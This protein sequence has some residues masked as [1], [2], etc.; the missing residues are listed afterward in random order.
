[1]QM[2]KVYQV[3]MHIECTLD[4]V[5]NQSGILGYG[6]IECIFYCFDTPLVVGTGTDTTDTHCHQSAVSWVTVFHDR[7]HPAEHGGRCI[8]IDDF[9]ALIN[10]RFHS[11]VAFNPCNRVNDDMFFTHYAFSSLFLPAATLAAA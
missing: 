5:T 3:V 9:I 7:L 11:Q 4:Q 6:N 1:M 8:G 10:N 2:V